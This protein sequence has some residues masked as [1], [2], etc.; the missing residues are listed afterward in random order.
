MGDSKLLFLFIRALDSGAVFE[1]VDIVSEN[2]DA[3]F[4]VT[5]LSFGTDLDQSGIR[6]FLQM[7]GDRCLRYGKSRND[8]ATGHFVGRCCHFLKDFK[9]AGIGQSFGDT[10]KLA[11]VHT[12]DHYT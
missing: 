1:F 12:R 10:L 8:S 5:E 6:Q 7:V 3:G 2:V 4:A 9:S 11:C